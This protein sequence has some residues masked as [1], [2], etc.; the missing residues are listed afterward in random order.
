MGYLH[1]G[2]LYKEQ[3]ILLF[4]ECYAMEKVHGTSA[5]I[6]W[7]DGKLTFFSGGERHEK[8]VS[9]FDQEK[10]R[11]EF[12]QRFGA[13]KVVVYGEAYGGKCQGMSHTYGP[14]LRFIAFDI[15][16]DEL[17]LNVPKMDKVATDLG[18][19]VVPWVKVAADVAALDAERDKPSEVAVR[20]GMGPDK[21]REGIVVRPLE[22]MT[23]NNGE[24]VVAK[25][26]GEKFSERA[27]PQRVVSSDK[28]AVL[29]AAE[30]IADEW[31]TAHR[32]EHVLGRIEVDEH[33]VGMEDT[34]KVIS[35]MIEDVFREAKDEIVESKEAKTAIGKKTVLLFKK[36][37][38]MI[39]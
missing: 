18:F 35:T 22:E 32:L 30:A 28:L 21:M 20:R 1:I 2:N 11:N 33:K 3:T 29:Q 7:S 6:T 8:F 17:W 27:T 10:L 12:E 16:I 24:R 36:H 19:E 15:Q 38:N 5:H 13:M 9:L 26:K 4:R 14:E 34:P 39:R 25:H 37:L 31:V 23:M